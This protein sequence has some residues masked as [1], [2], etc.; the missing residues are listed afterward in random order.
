MAV[1]RWSRLGGWVLAVALAVKLLWMGLGYTGLLPGV[2]GGEPSIWSPSR[3]DGLV[4]WSQALFLAGIV[5][6][7]LVRRPVTRIDDGRL[8]V[9]AWG[10]ALSLTLLLLVGAVGILFQGVVAPL[11]GDWLDERARQVVGWVTDQVPW[12]IP[13]V[14][15]MALPVG[16]VLLRWP[17]GSRDRSVA[18]LLLAFALWSLPRAV[19]AIRLELDPT[20]TLSANEAGLLDLIT[21][22]TVITLT[23]AALAVLW[24]LGQQRGAGPGALLTV[25]VTSTVLAHH[26]SLTPLDWRR[27][28]FYAALVFPA[29]YQF[30]FD[31]ERL[32][33]PGPARV[34]RVLAATGM[35]AV[36]VTIAATRLAI[37]FDRYS[38]DVGND[39]GRMLFAVPFA[40]IL[41]A[42]HFH[43][44][45]SGLARRST[46]R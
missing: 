21:L 32:N 31:A 25:L 45:A 17:G 40:A 26:A 37:D 14:V 35:A 46:T 2:L 29:V 38:P 22:D 23:V 39:P 5:V 20:T 15:W 41:L 33:Q 7:W 18:L 34:T 10:L 9:A 28:L 36:V 4:S 13:L 30:L 19:V 1:A 24:W 6:W 11:P 16:L 44:D 43:Q 27:A 3:H 12:N 8:A 42:A